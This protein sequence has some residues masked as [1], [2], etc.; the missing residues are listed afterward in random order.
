ML[1]PTLFGKMKSGGLSIQKL[2]KKSM[3]TVEL[4]NFPNQVLGQPTILTHSR[5]SYTVP[6]SINSDLFKCVFKQV[7][8]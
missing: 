5:G 8:M 3:D 4:L 6:P 7:H 2:H 1:R